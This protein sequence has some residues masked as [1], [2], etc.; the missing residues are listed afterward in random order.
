MALFGNFAHFGLKI[1]P[2]RFRNLPQ[3]PGDYKTAA[4]ELTSGAIR[5]L[6]SFFVKI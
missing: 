2:L 1:K 4:Q 3:N 5:M 6:L